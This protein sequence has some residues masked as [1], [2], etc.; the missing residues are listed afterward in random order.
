MS[1]RQATLTESRHGDVAAE[2]A[3][4]LDADGERYTVEHELAR[5]GRGRVWL[6]PDRTMQR[7]VAIKKPARRRGTP[8]RGRARGGRGRVWL[9]HDRTMQRTVAI[10]QPARRSDTSDAR[11]ERE[12]LITARLQH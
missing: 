1:S 6:A 3:T 9:A 5:G 11:F 4:R 10:K 2:T 12:G 8:D 7:T